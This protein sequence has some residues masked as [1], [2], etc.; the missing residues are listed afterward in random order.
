[1]EMS[2]SAV[3]IPGDTSSLEAFYE[4]REG[5]DVA[6]L[7][8]PH[9]LYGGSMDSEV[10]VSL[11]NALGG[12]GL[13]TLRFNFRG[14]GRS[15]GEYGEGVGEINDLLSVAAYLRDLG[16]E[17]VHIVGYSFGAWV[18][19]GSIMQ[20]LEA[21]SFVLVSPPIDFMS[22]GEFKIPCKSCL[23]TLGDSDQYCTTASLEKWLETQS[24][25]LST[26]EVE[27]IPGCDHFYWGRVDVLAARV[28]G[29]F[30]RTLRGGAFERSCEPT[31]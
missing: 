30:K 27:I 24:P 4:D 18:A 22:F 23:I 15:G 25:A 10:I 12:L 28:E 1:M 6:V 31:G 17:S 21:A 11:R 29:F 13:A 16:K 5:K 20:G 3:R 7:C 26:P 2:E 9:P 14:V 8:H 19:L